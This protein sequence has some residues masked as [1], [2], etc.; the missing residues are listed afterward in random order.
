MTSC[1]NKGLI[2]SCAQ[3]VATVVTD[4]YGKHLTRDS[5]FVVMIKTNWTGLLVFVVEDYRYSCFG[6]ASLTLLVHKVLQAVG[7]DL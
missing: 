1:S 5:D 2:G 3:V 4:R 7:S 6:D